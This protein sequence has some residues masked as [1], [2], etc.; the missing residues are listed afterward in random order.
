MKIFV[1]IILFI[2]IAG[3]DLVR[4]LPGND[5]VTVGKEG[6]GIDKLVD[7]VMKKI[8]SV[9]SNIDSFKETG[10][11][12]KEAEKS[13]TEI[14]EEYAKLLDVA[15]SGGEGEGSRFYKDGQ[16]T[17]EIV[18]ELPFP[19]DDYF[20]ECW[21][22]RDEPADHISAGQLIQET[23]GKYHLKFIVNSDY[24]DYNKLVITLEPD[25]DDFSPAAHILQG[26]F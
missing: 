12:F 13:D 4:P 1:L 19:K 20:Y 5:T 15:N 24:T 14:G 22:I 25:D 2:F 16:F 23:D 18:S 26:E 10:V 17:L 9:K 7:K 6:F 3:C 11:V 21:I 8:D